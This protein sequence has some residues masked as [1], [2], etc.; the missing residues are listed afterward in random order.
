MSINGS[1]NASRVIQIEP[2]SISW[3]LTILH[4]GYRVGTPEP[5]PTIVAQIIENIPLGISSG[6]SE[7]GI[8]TLVQY[9]I[10]W[11]TSQA[12][13]SAGGQND[14][15]MMTVMLRGFKLQR[16]NKQSQIYMN[17]N[18]KLTNSVSV[19]CSIRDSWI[20]ILFFCC[21]QSS[22]MQQSDRMQSEIVACSRGSASR[23]APSLQSLTSFLANYSTLIL[24]TVFTYWLFQ[25]CHSSVSRSVLIFSKVLSSLLKSLH[26]FPN[27]AAC[28]STLVNMH[29]GYLVWSGAPL[30]TYFREK[31]NF[32]NPDLQIDLWL[33]WADLELICWQG[34]HNL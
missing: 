3:D 13:F 5:W 28:G 26:I 20:F 34:V 23:K 4:H 17:Y 22:H 15:A 18:K 6:I 11:P 7:Q 1:S 25:G 14:G 19:T 21:M 27:S 2:K 8:A 12:L 9:S 32:W 29:F 30:C 24:L 33:V 16:T 10:N 31:K